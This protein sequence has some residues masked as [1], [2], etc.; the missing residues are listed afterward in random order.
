MLNMSAM[1]FSVFMIFISL[2]LSGCKTQNPWIDFEGME[3]AEKAF[4]ERQRQ[5]LVA[6]M[7]LETMFPDEQER[8]LAKAAGRGRVKKIDALVAQG[9]DV[10][11]RGTSN[12]TPL[13]WALK[14]RNLK[15]LTRLLELGADPNIMYD[16]GGSVMHWAASYRKY[17]LLKAVLEHNGDP[18]LVSSG[19]SNETPLFGFVIGMIPK[20]DDMACL[21]LLV[22]HGADVNA[23]GFKGSTPAMSA[24]NL[25]R[26]DLV[27][28]LIKQGA[29]YR[30]KR[31]NGDSLLDIIAS[32]RGKYIPGS[33][34]EKVLNEL[35]EWLQQRGI[36]IPNNVQKGAGPS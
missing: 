22:E 25:G 30:L 13:Y 23:R 29:D 31:D 4:N 15:G 36:S 35:I 26:Y 10:N 2:A 17:P 1:R 14:K 20:P 33:R 8:A 6:F 28:E 19:G 11:A 32:D 9:V 16:D 3:T 24:A 21:N 12:A 7:S 5:R 34:Q 27:Q 18:N